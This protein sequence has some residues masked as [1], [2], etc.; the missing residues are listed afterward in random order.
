MIENELQ[1]ET[2]YESFV[3]ALRSLVTREK[4]LG[5][6]AHFMSYIGITVRDQMKT[7]IP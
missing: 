3:F 6:L 7:Q 2:P 5:S 4:Y 1:F